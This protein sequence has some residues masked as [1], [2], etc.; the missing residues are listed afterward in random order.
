MNKHVISALLDIAV[1]FAPPLLAVA[2]GWT[3]R[4]RYRERE[5]RYAYHAGTVLVGGGAAVLLAV[6]AIMLMMRNW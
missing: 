2:G 5:P 1:L 4:R 3:L 6:F